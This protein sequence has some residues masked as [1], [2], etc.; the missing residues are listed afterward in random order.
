MSQS[1]IVLIGRIL[2]SV[3]FIMAGLTKLGDPTGNAAYFAS[4][5][6]PMAGLL[7]WLV[8]ALE[9]LGRNCHSDRFHDRTG[10]PIFWRC[11][12]SLLRS[13][14]ISISATRSSRSCS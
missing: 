1:T 6:L 9:V 4:V 11:S 7:V 8:I 10:R 13:W 2:L 14:R 5:G 3:M 12:V